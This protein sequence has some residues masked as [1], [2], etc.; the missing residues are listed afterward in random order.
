MHCCKM[1]VDTPEKTQMC[2]DAKG[3]E[4]AC[5]LVAKDA[6]TQKIGDKV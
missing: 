2:A 6:L 1:Q 5:G 4:Y 3:H